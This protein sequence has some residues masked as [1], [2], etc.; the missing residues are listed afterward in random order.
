MLRSPLS[1]V[2]LRVHMHKT[3]DVTVPARNNRD[4]HTHPEKKSQEH[5]KD[6]PL[7]HLQID[8]TE[9]D[10]REETKEI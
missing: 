3:S 7:G 10:H 5:T 4:T 8:T 6:A 9:G 2:S 1:D